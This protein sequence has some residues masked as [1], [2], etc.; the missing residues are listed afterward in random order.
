MST[1]P[2]PHAPPARKIRQDEEVQKA[3]EQAAPGAERSVPAGRRRGLTWAVI[4]GA[5]LVLSALLLLL[6]DQRVVDVPGGPLS[7]LH[8][9]SLALV[10]FFG[11]IFSEYAVEHFLISR[12]ESAVARYNLTRILRL[13]AALAVL[14]ILGSI[15]FGNIYTGLVSL[16]VMSII[17]GLAVQTPMTS[18]IGWLY[19]LVRA[20]Y[21]VGDRIQIGNATG[22]V[23]EVSYLDTTL[24]EFGG[25]YLSSDHPSGR[26]IKFPN[27]NVL[28]TA[29]YNYSW[30]LFPYIWNEI[31]LQ[32]GYESDLE[33]IATTM[34]E[35]AESEIGDEMQ[36]RVRVYRDLLA[37]TPVDE[38]TVQEKP[39]VLFRAS[40]NTWLEAVLRYLVDPKRAGRVKTALL[41]KLLARLN[42]APDKVLFPKGPNR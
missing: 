14:G 25:K 36:D 13:V 28:N 40:E 23:I 4:W 11:A 31:K 41:R 30:P 29:V 37:K 22:D 18:F 33:F 34:I 20:P 38:L 27:S 15:V 3:L 16:G 6:I 2:R 9:V 1:K 32:V 12:L 19:I 5:C 17:V 39:V 26:I 10:I 35:V 8:R 21:R 42:A 24:W 7:L